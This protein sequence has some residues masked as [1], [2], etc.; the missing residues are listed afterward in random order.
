[1]LH[2]NGYIMVVRKPEQHIFTLDS[3]EPTQHY[4]INT[5]KMI[6]MQSYTLITHS[7]INNNNP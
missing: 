7:L 3:R 1:M 4:F 5:H 2:L 6:Y